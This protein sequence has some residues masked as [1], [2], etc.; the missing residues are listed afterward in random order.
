MPCRS[1]TGWLNPMRSVLT[2]AG[3]IS[4]FSTMSNIA[5]IM[6]WIDDA[7]GHSRSA[8]CSSSQP[9]PR[10]AGGAARAV[11]IA[12]VETAVLGGEDLA[13]GDEL[14]LGQQRRHQPRKRAA[15]LVKLDRRRAPCG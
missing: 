11:G 6:P 12:V 10:A 9:L 3:S 13:R 15:T 2:C 8:I 4:C 14:L 5:V 7:D 1:N